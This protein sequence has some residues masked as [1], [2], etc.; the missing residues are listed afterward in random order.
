MPLLDRDH[1]APTWAHVYHAVAHGEQDPLVRRIMLEALLPRMSERTAAFPWRLRNG[2]WI[3]IPPAEGSSRWRT[4]GWSCFLDGA[5][6][7]SVES[8]LRG[9]LETGQTVF[10][11]GAN[12]GVFTALMAQRVGK[13]GRVYAFEPVV[14]T[15][16]LLN[17]TVRLNAFR[18]VRTLCLALGDAAA[19]RDLY[20][21]AGASANGSLYRDPIARL[22]RPVR[23]TVRTLDG[24][25]EAGTVAPP[26][27]IKIDVEGHEL[28]VL[29]GARRLLAA[30]RPTLLLELNERMSRLAGWTPAHLRELL[31]ACG[32]YRCFRLEAGKRHP[33]D[34]STLAL[35][36]NSALDLVAF[37]VGPRAGG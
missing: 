24:L 18:Q 20:F 11:V 30:Y 19:Q 7:P 8:A 25:L 22:S 29:Q 36:R 12:L 31:Q 9:C 26:A 21:H 13:E 27:L 4:I 5:W 10:D 6:E 17:T 28:A 15:Y 14:D 23:V 3:A 1:T 33:I 34:L 16:R 2:L 37:P 35:E 32:G